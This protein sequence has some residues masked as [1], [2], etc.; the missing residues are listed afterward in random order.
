MLASLNKLGVHLAS[1]GKFVAAATAFERALNIESEPGVR[2]NY[3]NVLRR[4]WRFEEAAKALEGAPDNDFTRFVRGS[5]DIETGD[6]ISAAIELAFIEDQTAHI[7][8]CRAMASL[9]AKDWKTG[10]ELYDAR[11]EM[12]EPLR[13]DLPRWQGEQGA[14]LAHHEQGFGDGL[15]F[16]R[17]LN[18]RTVSVPGALLR[19]FL[20]SGFN[21]VSMTSHT[22][23]ADY[24]SPLMSLPR[25]DGVDTIEPPAPYMRAHEEYPIPKPPGTKLT[26]GLVWTAKAQDSKRGMEEALHGWQKS[27]PL[28]LLLPLAAIP[29]VQL[30]GLQT[31]EAAKDVPRIGADGLIINVGTA[32]MDFADLAAFM[33]S[34]DLIVTVDT[35]PIHLAGAMGKPTIGLLSYPRSWQWPVGPNPWYRTVD[36][37]QQP[38]PFDWEGVVAILRERIE[39]MV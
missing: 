36:L 17:F 24:I 13:S 14:V 9:Q 1:T 5:L 10:F 2:V 11:L 16:A 28:E 33:A 8:F 25:W 26:V 20:A 32:V 18:G 39:A 7:R 21:A 23:K 38:K 15:M 34:M 22:P 29:G 31:G 4:M 35:A 27:I 6:P 3:A 37:I 19:L 30:Y 12:N